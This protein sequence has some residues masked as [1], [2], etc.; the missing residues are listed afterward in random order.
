MVGSCPFQP[1]AGTRAPP[2]GGDE[3]GEKIDVW[4]ET[5]DASVDVV[6]WF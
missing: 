6:D 5:S 4:I 1:E 2:D 3:I